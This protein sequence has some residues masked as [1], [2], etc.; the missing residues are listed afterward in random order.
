MLMVIP[1][2]TEMELD[3]SELK[4]HQSPGDEPQLIY[5]LFMALASL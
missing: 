1:G 3:H 5:S 2:T 4:L